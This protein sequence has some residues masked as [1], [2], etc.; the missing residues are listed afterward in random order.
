MPIRYLG[1]DIKEESRNMSQG[2]DKK[3]IKTEESHQ[4][5]GGISSQSIGWDHQKQYVNTGV[6][7]LSFEVTSFSTQPGEKEPGKTKKQFIR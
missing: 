1:G 3:E 2:E 6:P 7:G 5:L 4:L